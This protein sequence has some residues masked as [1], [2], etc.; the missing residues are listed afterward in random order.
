MPILSL[1]KWLR[2][3]PGSGTVLVTSSVAG[4][5]FACLTT[6]SGV[7]NSARF[8]SFGTLAGPLKLAYLNGLDERRLRCGARER[9][10]EII[11][12]IM[13]Q[14][15]WMSST[16]DFVVHVTSSRESG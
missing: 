8:S 12:G 1:K 2:R 5:A 13:H 15:A 11:H 14:Y 10:I 4:D 9:E 3:G 16:H 6:F 7:L